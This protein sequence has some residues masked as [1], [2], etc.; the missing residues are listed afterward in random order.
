ELIPH[1]RPMIMIDA[2]LE[3]SPERGVAAK[4]FRRQDYGLDGDVVCETALVECVAQTTAALF[5]YHRLSNSGEAGLGFLAALSS[6][7]FSRRPSVN[8]PL[9]IEAQV[10][11]SF[12][13]MWIV[14]GRVLSGGEL[15]AWGEIKIYMQNEKI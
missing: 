12:G 8:E 11:R 6:F 10:V 13:A 5:G 7:A 4:T 9:R 2:L 15:V 14:K 3:A 1:R